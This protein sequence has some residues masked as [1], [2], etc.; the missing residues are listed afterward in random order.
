MVS[1]QVAPGEAEI[2]CRIR[3]AA[4]RAQRR[5]RFDAEQPALGRFV[6]L[7]QVDAGRVDAAQD[8]LQATADELARVL[9]QSC[10]G[11]RE[12]RDPA[13]TKRRVVAAL[14]LGAQPRELRLYRE[15]IRAVREQD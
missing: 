5:K 1:E 10:R 4:E 11:R 13:D 9:G 14:E 15:M 7:L 6:R 12:V 3:R 2:R 8:V